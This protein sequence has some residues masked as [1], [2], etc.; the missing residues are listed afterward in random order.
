MRLEPGSLRVER[1][2][3]GLLTALTVAA[4][5]A[6]A[7]LAEGAARKDERQMRTVRHR[8]AARSRQPEPSHEQEEPEPSELEEAWEEYYRERT[9]SLRRERRANQRNR[10]G[11]CILG[12]HGAVIYAPPGS[13][14]GATAANANSSPSPAPRP[15][16]GPKPVSPARR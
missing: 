4:F 2:A 5:A 16:P 14:C 12:A 9:E 7:A 1:F 6:P 13:D 11:T 10:G 15:E 8:S 3:I